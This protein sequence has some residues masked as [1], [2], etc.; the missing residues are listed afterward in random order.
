MKKSN[1]IKR[2]CSVAVALALALGSMLSLTSCNINFG[3]NLGNK[4]ESP[5]VNISDELDLP[6]YIRDLIKLDEVFNYYSYEGVDEEAMKVALLKAYIEATGDIHAEY[7][8]AEE[9]EQYF[10]DRAG[11]FVGIG[12]SVVNTVITIEG[13][14]YRVICVVNVFKDSPAMEAGLLPGDC[15]V[16]VGAGEDRALVDEIGYTEALERV[17]GVEGTFVDFTVFRPSEES[18]IF[19]SAVSI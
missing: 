8:D 13:C 2:F 19:Q 3:N 9:Y 7:L 1:N 14:Q 15:V 5:D 18:R 11:E 12:V 16:Y 17:R 10:S 4:L 6:E